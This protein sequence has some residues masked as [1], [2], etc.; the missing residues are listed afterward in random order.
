MGCIMPE[1]EVYYRR[2]EQFLYDK[3]VT[4]KTLVKTHVV[5]AIKRGTMDEVF[6]DMQGEFMDAKTRNLVIPIIKKGLTHHQS[7][8]VGDVLRD[9][10]TGKI[11]QC[12]M[13]GWK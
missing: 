7:M 13:V 5:V 2:H 4:P 10:K 9:R 1:F 3:K 8:S 11:Y 6:R 12:D